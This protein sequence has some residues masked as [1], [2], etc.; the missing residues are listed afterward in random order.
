MPATF[1]I[2]LAHKPNAE[3]LYDVRLRI[4]VARV[5]VYAGLG[6]SVAAKHWNT[7]AT[8]EKENWIKTGDRLASQ[9]NNDLVIALLDAKRLA[10]ALPNASAQHL[11][12]AFL[13][14]HEPETVNARPDFVAFLRQ[15]VEEVDK[16]RFT[17]GTY[18]VRAAVVNKFA[19]WRAGQP[20]PCDKLTPEVMA[21]FDAYMQ[22]ELGNNAT[23]RRK[24]LKVLGLYIGRAIRAK[25]LSRDQDPLTDYTM[26]KGKPKRVWLTDEELAAYEQVRLPPMQ[27]L[28]RL[29]YLLCFYLHGSRIGV[30]L[31]LQWKHR[32]FGRIY[33]TADKG[34]PEKS[35]SESA[36]LRAILDSLI[37]EQ[38]ADPEAYILP[39]LDTAYERLPP[40]E[41][42]QCIKRATAKVNKNIKMGA[43]KCG[44]TKKLSTHSSRR[45][46]ATA[47]DR[48]NGGDLGKVGSLLGHQQRS[49]TEIYLDRYNSA[50]VD[51][52]AENVYQHRKMPL[53]KAG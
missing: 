5:P 24:N 43:S 31:R 34:G 22:R 1:K 14:R 16:P 28:A 21:E 30:V 52:A 46:L 15:N 18:E 3:G 33:F 27:H 11:K 40:R 45:T 39:W 47:A 26:P 8:L 10:R 9:H 49:T 25:L 32:Q 41:R 37:P 53:L 12:E 19:T 23:T 7:G 51:Q 35:V 2:T 13:R 20:L 29:T 48:A 4:I 36:Q 6:I 42:L 44:I 50:E 17:R 38:G